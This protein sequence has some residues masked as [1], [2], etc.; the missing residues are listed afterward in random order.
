MILDA[1]TH[2]LKRNSVY[3]LPLNPLKSKIEKVDYFCAGIHPWDLE[4]IESIDSTLFEIKKMLQHEKCVAVG[5][6]GLD[7]NYPN[8]GLQKLAMEAQLKMAIDFK[9]PVVI[10]CVK[11]LSD[12]LSILKNYPSSLKIYLHGINLNSEEIVQVQKRNFYIGIGTLAFKNSKIMRLAH[13]LPKEK[14]LI[15][16]DD[17]GYSVQNF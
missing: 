5:E 15:E 3:S 14:I 17:S 12:I 2:Q 13:L 1:H 7:R 4:R 6:I 10:H 11:A 16:T 8:L 9:L